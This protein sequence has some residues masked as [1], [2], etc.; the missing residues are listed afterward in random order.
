MS[1]SRAHN[2]GAYVKAAMAALITRLVAGGAG[3]NTEVVGIALDRQSYAYPLS[4]LFI[5]I[6]RATL[7]AAATLTLKTVVIE[8]SDSSTFASGNVTLLAPADAALLTDGGGGGVSSGQVS[9]SVDLASAKRYVRLRH[10]PDLSAA[11]TDIAET[12]VE[13]IF[14][15]SDSLS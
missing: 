8:T 14:G 2:I 7:A 1:F 11:N 4:A 13:C 3:D 10:T 12:A 5:I 15:G 6:G 9:F